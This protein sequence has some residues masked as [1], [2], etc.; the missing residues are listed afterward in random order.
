MI[1]NAR[2]RNL[3]WLLIVSFAVNLTLITSLF[4][5]KVKY[6]G[7]LKVTTSKQGDIDTVRNAAFFIQNLNLTE[8]QAQSFRNLHRRYN[9]TANRIAADLNNLRIQMVDELGQNESNSDRLSAIN[10]NFGLLHEELKDATV[11]Y[12]L[13]MKE[14]CDSLQ[15]EQLYTLF[16]EMVS[17]EQAG[18]GRVGGR[19]G[20]GWQNRNDSFIE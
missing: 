12:Y 5:N 7:S 13:S 15:R 2:Y 11:D 3:K 18:T 6:T 4:Y 16:S 17:V 14:I 20:R 10:G 1:T 9:R 8:S 19:Y